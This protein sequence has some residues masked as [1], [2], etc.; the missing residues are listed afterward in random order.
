MITA[1]L[2]EPSTTVQHFATLIFAV[3][4]VHTFVSA[5]IGHLAHRYPLNSPPERLFHLLGEVEV[6]F[7]L[8]AAV[9]LFGMCFLSGLDPAVHYVESLDFTEPA[10]V[11][12]VMTMAATRPVLYAADKF[13][14]RIAS[15]LPLHPAVSYFWVT[16]SVGPLLGSF[17]TEPAAMTVAAMILFKNFYG[18]D[19]S[20]R[21]N[22][23]A[24]AAL[25]VNVSIGG[26]LTH[27]AAP[28]VL[29]VAD[30]WGWDLD[31]MIRHFGYKSAIATLLIASY[32]TW[33]LRVELRG[34]TVEALH[35]AEDQQPHP[36]AWLII[37]HFLFLSASVFMAHHMA[38]FI[39]IFLLFMGLTMVTHYYQ[40]S[41]R[42]DKSL[43]VAL[44]LGGLVVLGKMQ[45]WWIEP[46]L[47]GFADELLFIATTLLTAITDNAALTYLGAQVENITMDLKYALVAG[48]VTG[49]GLTVIANAPNPAGFAILKGAFKD[50]VINP[51]Q[52]LLR[53]LIPTAIAAV[54]LWFLPSL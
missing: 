4:I 13:I 39:G 40:T 41:L 48:A 29:M 34:L 45:A 15:W 1:E 38:V 49:G 47:E 18:R 36:P 30:T 22:Y 44:F 46:I 52:L 8:W 43:L 35:Q 3:A 20:C 6:V 9:F 50:G 14:R 28:P 19:L 16:L 54:C 2:V 12:I 5:K 7:G 10:F 27:F 23:I 33:M 32:S 53:A 37:A 25:L 17:I 21:F 51:G 24:L 42:Y 31:F 26:T 11:F